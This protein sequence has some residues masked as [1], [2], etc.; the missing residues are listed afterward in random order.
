MKLALGRVCE[1]RGQLDEAAAAYGQ[2]AELDPSWSAPRVAALGVR[3]R[4][5]DA[6]GAL[7]G[8][9][10]LPEELRTIG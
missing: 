3:L 4:Q 7:V 9:R 5:G 6:A 2:A 10:G 8:L 1:N